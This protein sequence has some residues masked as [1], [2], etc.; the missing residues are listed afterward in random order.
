MTE[1]GLSQWLV[2]ALG[3]YAEVYSNN[4]GDFFTDD[5][6]NITG[7]AARSYAEFVADFAGAFDS[8]PQAVGAA[9]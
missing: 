8:S 7:A 6:E 4:Y 3:E 1:M 5:V 2:D 9:R